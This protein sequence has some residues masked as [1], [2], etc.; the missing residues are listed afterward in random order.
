[1]AVLLDPG[2]VHDFRA[3]CS[4]HPLP[5]RAT[6]EAGGFLH[7]SSWDYLRSVVGIDDAGSRAF[8][9]LVVGLIAFLR[10]L[11][12]AGSPK[13]A[14]WAN[15]SQWATTF[16]PEPQRDIACRV[17][18]ILI[19]QV[20]VGLDSLAPNARFIED[21]GMTDLEPVEVVMALEVEFGFTIPSADCEPLETIQDLVCYLH[22]RRQRNYPCHP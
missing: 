22:Q 12:K 8:L 14:L 19:E 1:M 5:A 4:F 16:F 11:T 3:P 21:L 17:A 6:L 2:S 18:D 7:G 10:W 20:G 15:T 9:E 13:P